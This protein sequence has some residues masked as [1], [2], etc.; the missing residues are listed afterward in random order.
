MNHDIVTVFFQGNMSSRSQAANYAGSEG[1]YVKTPDIEHVYV[2]NAPLILHNIFTYDDLNDVGYGFSINPLHWCLQ[3]KSLVVNTYCG[4]EG[5]SLSYSYI[6]ENNVGGQEDVNQH[7][8]AIHECIKA[9]PDKKIVLFGC[10]RGAA[11]TLVTLSQLNKELLKHI[12][13]VIV[14]APFDSVPNVIKSSSW[15]PKLT[16]NFLNFCTKYDEYQTS[17]LDA[18]MDDSFPLDV[19]I[20]FITSKVDTRV[21]IDN[22]LRLINVLKNKNHTKLHHLMLENSHHAL[23]FRDNKE[24]QDQYLKFVNHLYDLYI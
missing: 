19:P 10:S 12:T 14:E 16:M 5:S 8:R 9:H 24:D 21:P 23:M 15:F 7:I 18:V 4:I 6:T 13:L 3:L 17:P 1:L 11:T 20:A 2:P 22:T